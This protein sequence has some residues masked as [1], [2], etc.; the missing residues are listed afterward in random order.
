MSLDYSNTTGVDQKAPSSNLEDSP[1][2]WWKKSKYPCKVAQQLFNGRNLKYWGEKG[3]NV[4]QYKTY[5]PSMTPMRKII[6]A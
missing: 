2:T 3:R 1:T 6:N 4:G 5:V